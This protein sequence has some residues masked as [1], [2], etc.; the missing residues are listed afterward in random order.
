MQSFSVNAGCTEP[1]FIVT[2]QYAPRFTPLQDGRI[3]LHTVPQADIAI[4][5]ST[6]LT[7]STRIEFRAEAFN[8][9]N[10]FHFYDVPFVNNPNNANFGTI[11]KATAASGGSSAPR[12]V[13]LAVK[14]I[15]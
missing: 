12:Q 2:P 15:W 10:T 7:E 3:R 6:Q 14:F 1:N 13:Q 9:F 5:K 11:T 4:V 8:A